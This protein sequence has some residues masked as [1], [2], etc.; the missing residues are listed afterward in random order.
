[1]PPAANSVPATMN[2]EAG[3]SIPPS[4]SSAT[5]A[6]VGALSGVG[7]AGHVGGPGSGARLTGARDGS[8]AASPRRSTFAGFTADSAAASPRRSTFAGFTADSDAASPR[9]SC[10]AAAAFTVLA[11]MSMIGCAA[12]AAGAPR[13]AAA[14]EAMARRDSVFPFGMT[15][16]WS[17][18]IA[19]GEGAP[20]AGDTPW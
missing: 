6:V 10:S 1:M 12:A 17:G 19:E 8:A 3:M 20:R 18:S 2:T 13:A 7:S 5:T 16:P 14:S 11:C 9:R 15:P 4:P